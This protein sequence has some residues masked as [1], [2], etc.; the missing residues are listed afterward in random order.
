MSLIKRTVLVCGIAAALSAGRANAQSGASRF[1]MP[2]IPIIGRPYDAVKDFSI[3]KN[4]NGPWSYGCSS[5]ATATDFEPYTDAKT[6]NPVNRNLESWCGNK[7]SADGAPSITHNKGNETI[8]WQG[9]TFPTDFLDLHPGSQ[10]HR[11][12]LRFTVPGRGTYKV[13]GAFKALDQTT[14]DP[15]VLVNGKAAVDIKPINPGHRHQDFSFTQ[16]LDK[17]DTI[18]FA[19]GNGGNGYGYDSTGLMLAVTPVSGMAG[20][21][22]APAAGPAKKSPELATL[23]ANYGHQF[24]TININGEALIK[25]LKTDYMAVLADAEKAA[26]ARG[27]LD[28]VLAVRGEMT[29][30]DKGIAP[31]DAEKAALPDAVSKAQAQYNTA[32]MRVI[33]DLQEK[34]AQVQKQYAADLETLE[35]TLTQRGNIDGAMEVRREREQNA[36]NAAK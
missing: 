16:Q 10:G 3:T 4:P 34:Q 31:T 11:S 24:K 18:D 12:V 17:G 30:V 13:Q 15:H 20:G 33:G 27:N 21:P 25:R 19:V 8:R 2:V 29:R 7:G 32:L 22:M 28:A 1:T 23:V 9:I 35:H 14:T 26:K 36:V 6:K 5:S